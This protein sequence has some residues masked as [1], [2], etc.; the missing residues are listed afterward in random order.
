MQVQVEKLDSSIKIIVASGV[1]TSEDRHAV[2]IMIHN[3]TANVSCGP[4]TAL[5]GKPN[6]N[7]LILPGESQKQNLRDIYAEY[8]RTR[9]LRPSTLIGYNRIIYKYLEDWLSL[10]IES[11]D[12]KRFV[13]KCVAVR[14]SA[15]SAQAAFTSRVFKA[16]YAF[17]AFKYKFSPLNFT[18]ALRYAGI[19]ISIKRRTSHIPVHKRQAWFDAVLSLS[20]SKAERTARDIFL[21]GVF[22]GLR[23]NEIMRLE[24]ADIDL[25]GKILTVRQTKNHSDH[26]LPLDDFLVRVLDK[27]R[28]GCSSAYVFTGKTGMSPV[29]DIDDMTSKVSDAA[30]VSFTLHDL[31]RTFATVASETGIPPYTIKRLLNHSRAADVT[32]G[33]IIHT[34]ESLREPVF[35]IAHEMFPDRMARV[36]VL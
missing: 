21:V 18:R 30:G 13:D 33:Y 32:A 35:K 27:R 8:L 17:A 31:R 25:P 20:A 12:E 3:A 9:Q 6:K 28:G 36:G 5:S 24:W 10:P 22:L 2:V 34:V 19:K 23:K 1:G 4:S 16:V 7:I 14:D 11:I 26:T 29:R 15:G